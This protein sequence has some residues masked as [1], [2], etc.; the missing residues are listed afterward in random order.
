V[1]ELL[2]QDGWPDRA[3]AA[4]GARHPLGGVVYALP[5]AEA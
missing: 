3:A 2:R 4:A 5:G 1:G